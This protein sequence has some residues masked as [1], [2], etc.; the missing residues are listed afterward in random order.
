MPTIRSRRIPG[1]CPHK[2]SGQAIVRLAGKVHYL[3]KVGTPKSYAKYARL[4]ADWNGGRPEP[5][6]PQPEEITII[7]LIAAWRRH[8]VRHY[9][10]D[11]Q[12]TGEAKNFDHAAKPLLAL[13]GDE[14]ARDFGPLK[15]QAVRSLLVTGFTTRLGKPVAPASRST[16][17]ARIGRI[18]R[19]F[20]W[21]ESQELVPPSLSH[22]LATVKG[23]Q[24]GRT[25]ARETEPIG[26]ADD[27]HVEA[28]LA[29]LPPVVADMARV[30]RLTGCRPGEVCAMRPV[31]VDRGSTPWLYR[32]ASHKTE[33]HGRAR[34]IFIGPKAQ[35]I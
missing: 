28:T 3:G 9:R 2:A 15:L 22:A 23:L 5:P 13:Y 21:A 1:Y 10:K 11:G 20:R 8:A 18:K 25:E 17:N 32:P 12:P 34:V 33:H 16:V 14:L 19:I 24:R 31:D 6:R 35:Q 4:I 27:R 29:C 7:E 30:Q 26:P